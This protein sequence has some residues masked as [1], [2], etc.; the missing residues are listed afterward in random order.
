MIVTGVI[1]WLFVLAHES[2]V[3]AEEESRRQN[4]LMMEEIVAHERTDQALQQAKEQA[5][6][7]TGRKVATLRGS[8]TNSVPRSMPSSAMPS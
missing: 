3:V 2:R 8:V 7:A 1:C 5:E 6:A 4:R